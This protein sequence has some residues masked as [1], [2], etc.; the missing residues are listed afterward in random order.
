MTARNI[1]YISS[2]LMLPILYVFFVSLHLGTQG[3]PME[4]WLPKWDRL[5]IL[6]TILALERIYSY[7]YAVSQRYI[8]SRDIIANIVNLY[9]TAAVVGALLLPVLLYLTQTFLG[10]KYVLASPEML[11]PVWLQIPLI[12]VM[13]SLV[14]YWMHR[15]QHHNEFLWKL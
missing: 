2:L 7:R 12:L 5:L 15:W 3:Q 13:V 10:H 8:L 1:F 11:G 14:R 4:G 9:I 6:V